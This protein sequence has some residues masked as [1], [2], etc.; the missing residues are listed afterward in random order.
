M[1]ATDEILRQ[2]YGKL[3]WTLKIRKSLKRLAN[4]ET[5]E[6]KLAT[7]EKLV[8]RTVRFVFIFSTQTNLQLHFFFIDW[9]KVFAFQLMEVFRFLPRAGWSSGR[10]W[11]M[12]KQTAFAKLI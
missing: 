6:Q 10:W 7:F 9:C 1:D 3:A 2:L 11:S 12:G 4:S 5:N 8:S